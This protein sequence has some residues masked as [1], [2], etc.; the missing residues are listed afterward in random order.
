[1]QQELDSAP[2]IEELRECL[3]NLRNG[4]VAGTDGISGDLLK[5]NAEVFLCPLFELI[6]RY[7]EQGETPAG[8]K[9]S[10]MIT[11]C[12]GQGDRG[13]CIKGSCDNFRGIS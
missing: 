2:N 12:K 10:V 13:S 11:L 4:K 5:A 3:H 7:W 6:K 8:M 9:G 1:V